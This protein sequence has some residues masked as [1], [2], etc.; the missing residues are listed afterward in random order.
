MPAFRLAPALLA[1]ALLALA[2][3]RGGGA[4]V[5]VEAAPE[6]VGQPDLLG[7]WTVA[8]IDGRAPTREVMLQFTPQGEFIRIEGGEQQRATY[9]FAGERALE[10][11]DATG[12]RRYQ[13]DVRDDRTI[14]LRQDGNGGEEL[15]LLRRGGPTDLSQVSPAPTTA[16]V[17]TAVGARPA[18]PE[19]IGP[20]PAP[21]DTGAAG[22]GAG[23]GGDR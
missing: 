13:I 14:I 8:E 1:L 17:D 23:T 20:A 12:V 21:A 18:G 2:A 10:L 6:N 7:A 5:E 19:G 15:R 3:C 11:T 4:D 9:V 16:L 22:A